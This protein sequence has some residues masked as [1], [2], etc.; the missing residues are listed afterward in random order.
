MA[1]QQYFGNPDEFV[2]VHAR[3]K[4]GDIVQISGVSVVSNRGELSIRPTE[5]TVLSPSVRVAPYGRGDGKYKVSDAAFLHRHREVE[6]LTGG[7]PSRLVFEKRAKAIQALRN[8][9][10]Q[11][12]FLE[13]ETPILH[14]SAGGAFAKPFKTT[15]RGLFLRIAPELALKRLIVGGYDRVFE[16]GRVFRD[17][18]VSLRHNPEFTSC[19]LYQAYS[20]LDQAAALTRDILLTMSDAVGADCSEFKGD[21]AVVSVADELSKL[22]LDF[23]DP[24]SIAVPRLI[25]LCEKLNVPKPSH[26][27]VPQLLDK[28]IGANVEALCNPDVPTLVTEHPV[29]SRYY[30]FFLSFAIFLIIFLKNIS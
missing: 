6:L 1:D 16:I 22:G 15:E 4:R 13:V 28:L 17:E 21:F 29:A 26:C 3:L 24:D 30:T 5:T 14:S 20:T 23:A 10:V 11:R 19:E 9:L 25:D 7:A 27:S 2:N 8:L 18:G 12:D